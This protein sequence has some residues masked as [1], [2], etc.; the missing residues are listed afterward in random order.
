[1]KHAIR[2]EHDALHFSASHF[3]TFGTPEKVEALHG[4]NFRIKAAVS[5]PLN[6]REYVVDFLIA[7]DSLKKICDMLSHKVLIPEKHPYITI[8]TVEET[9]HVSMPPL[10]WAFPAGDTLVLPIRNTTTESLAEF[11]AG[12]FRELLEQESAF[13]MP[14]THYGIT[15]ELE[16]SPGM[17][18]V[19][20]DKST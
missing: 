15:I 10:Q 18:A 7:F 1:M 19:F 2:F 14:P 3:I 5:G 11:I 9:V 4:H 16:E 17:W 13:E 20:Q 8:K 6:R 12:H